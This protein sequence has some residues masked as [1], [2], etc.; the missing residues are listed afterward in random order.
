MGTTANAEGF[1]TLT[2]AAG[3]YQLKAQC[4]GYKQNTFDVSLTENENLKHDFT[5]QIQGYEL[6]D[7]VVKSNAE[8]PAYRIIRNAI[9][10][11]TFHLKQMQSFQTS[12]YMKGVFR[13]RSTPDKI[14]GIKI[15]GEN[16]KE[17][18]DG[19]GL[20][21]AGKGVL[22]LCEEIADYYTSGNKEKL[23]VRSVKESGD[24]NGVG[25][26]N[27]PPVINFY[28]NNVK[29]LKVNDA[30]EAGFVSPISA[31]ALNYY[32]Y[33]LAGDFKE[34][35]YTIYK[36]N[37]I[38]K[39]NFERCFV[40][41][42][43]IVDEDWAVH[44]ARL[45]V[46]KKQGLDLLDTI[47][48]EQQYI[49]LGKDLWVIKNQVF[50]PTINLLGFDISGNFVTVY[51]NQ[52][53][54]QP[55]PDSIFNKKITMS[56]E[57][58]ANKKDSA[59]WQ[60]FRPMKLE[61]DEIRNYVYKDSLH[62][63]E[64]DPARL[65]SLR[66][67]ANKISLSE[68]LLGGYAYNSKGY[69]SKFSFS[70]VLWSLNFNVV[71]GL[72]YAPKLTYRHTI[73]TGKALLA[74]AD[75]RYG[76]GNTHFNGKGLVRYTQAQKNWSGRNWSV[77][78]T[79]GKYISQ[80]NTDQPVNE[81]YNTV[82]S[83]LQQVN[84]FKIF[85]RWLAGLQFKRNY[86]NGFSWQLTAMYEQR[87]PL[88][89]NTNFSF[90]EKQNLQA[91]TPNLPDEFASNPLIKHNAVIAKAQVSYQPGI[92]YTQYPDRKVMQSSNAP[93]FTIHYQKGIPDLL[94]SIVDY[95]KWDFNIEDELSLKRKGSIA[96]NATIGGFM[97]DKYVA[98]PDM[99]HLA[100]NQYLLASPGL[101]SFQLAPYYRYSNT[102]K[103]YGE[104]HLE[105]NLRGFITNKIPLLRQAQWYLVLGNNTFYTENNKYYTEAYVGLDNLGFK[106]FRFLRVDYIRGWDSEKRSYS[107]FRIGLKT[108]GII[109]IGRS[110]KSAEF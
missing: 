43:Y 60:N 98:I 67:R 24:P 79:G 33:K 85:E 66:I 44:S 64:N 45:F 55:I 2:L 81:L 34:N 39:R 89:N 25:V 32:S 82:S 99:K 88:F 58:G 70:P 12:I 68:I 17:M 87:I 38:P 48:T 3:K 61:D 63:V 106:I 27:V 92:T 72:N 77:A 4:I 29:V 51:D 9:K 90:V 52:K 22:Y 69:K 50:Y 110:E 28:E 47:K 101:Q 78:L 42:I 6:K 97:S 109:S 11:R 14:M 74:Q 46:T 59:Y 91:Y 76:F 21:T 73:D 62:R 93:V 56:Y 13:N 71:E 18:N 105:Y 80:L 19:M 83:L 103:L 100:G 40:G 75:L 5:L 37:V 7:I 31:G 1:Y 41:D 108:N 20:D 84:H 94:N 86:G 36:I 65:D 16:K 54:N 104:L 57:L 15:G 107:G 96:Y 49:P 35:G 8:D 30:N 23:L 102:S 26:G 10:R 95:D 53:V